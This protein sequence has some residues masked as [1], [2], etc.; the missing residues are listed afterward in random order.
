M[1]NKNCGPWAHEW[2][3]KTLPGTSAEGVEIVAVTNVSGDCDLGQRKG[4][5]VISCAPVGRQG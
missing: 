4:K 3:R 2:V 5:S 1:Q